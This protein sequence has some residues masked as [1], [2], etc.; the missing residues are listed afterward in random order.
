MNNSILAGV[1]L[2]G[3]VVTAVGAYASTRV[4]FN[5]WQ[6]YADVVAV[7]P[8]FDTNQVARQVCN[9]EAV[10]QQVP[11]KDE[12]RIAGTAIGAVIGGVLGNQ[13]GDGSGQK[14]ATAAG[15]VAGGYAGSKVQKR[16]QE[17]N[18][19][20]SMEQ[21][22]ETVYDSEKVPAG[23]QVTY[24]LDGKQGVVRMDHNPGNRIRIENGEPVLT[25]S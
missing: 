9:D 7:E 3:V 2:G 11:V 17:G 21:R 22:C 16:M 10:T 23:Y 5:P 25:K 6:D 24:L 4:D 13:V 15:A 12:K 14:L 19:E 20:T 18:M 1:I 8:A